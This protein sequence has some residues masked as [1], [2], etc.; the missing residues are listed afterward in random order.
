MNKKF[1]IYS[2]IVDDGCK[3]VEQDT[4]PSDFRDFA[5]GLEAGDEVTLNI[6][7]VGGSVLAGV[8]IA[9]QIK[10]LNTKGVRT[11]AKIEGLCASIATVI[12]C[13]CEKIILPSTSFVMIHN[14]W[15]MVQGDSNELRKQ[16]D[17]MDTMN[18][19]IMSF[20]KTK[21]SLTEDELKAMMDAETW[22]SGE[23]AKNYNLNCEVVEDS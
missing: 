3:W 5:E 9:N 1:D 12:M 6:N 2:E 19:V 23:E 13:A 18:D 16:A 10:A 14:C 15:T 20:Y 21:F 17:V 4:S 7:S 22:F 8:A 11:T